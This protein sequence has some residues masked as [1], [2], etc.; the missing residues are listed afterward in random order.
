MAKKTDS[1]CSSLL[2]V[3]AV[4]F[5]LGLMVKGGSGGKSPS[6]ATTAYPQTGDYQPTPVV[7]PPQ[8][9]LPLARDGTVIPTPENYVPKTALIQKPVEVGA[10][11]GKKMN[12]TK[13]LPA[14]TE[15][16]IKEVEGYNLYIE[17]D[18]H[19]QIIAAAATDILEQ[20]AQATEVVE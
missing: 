18:G 5:F 12:G 6:T 7:A 17:V 8:V 9:K 2:V 3:G 10:W 19:W 15:V 1:G 4:M 11:D 13:V 14:G 16:K 20:M